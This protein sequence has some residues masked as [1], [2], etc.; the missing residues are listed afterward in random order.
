MNKIGS[1]IKSDHHSE[2]YLRQHLVL[3][4]PPPPHPQLKQVLTFSF[5]NSDYFILT[6]NSSNSLFTNHPAKHIQSFIDVLCNCFRV[7]VVNVY[8]SFGSFWWMFMA[9]ILQISSRAVIVFPSVPGTLP[10]VDRYLILFYFWC[11]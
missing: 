8:M 11:T 4:I 7:Y 10:N 3:E 2:L 9:Q 1:S 5:R 6:Y